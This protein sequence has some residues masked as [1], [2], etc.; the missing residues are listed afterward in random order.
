MNPNS[1]QVGGSHY[2]SA[3]QHWDFVGDAL[4]GRYLEG[5]IS[6]YVSRWRKKG[7]T[8]DLEKAAHY[9]DKL[10]Q[11]CLDREAKPLKKN[12]VRRYSAIKFCH[13][14]GLIGAEQ[15]VI[16]LLAEWGN[17]ADLMTVSN[18]LANLL[19]SAQLEKDSSKNS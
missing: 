12:A 9:A 1:T 3:Y 11:A 8:Q 6:K 2:Q 7:G 13:K 15:S 4:Q 10:Q 14:N 19:V 5:C 17:L 16:L 18:L